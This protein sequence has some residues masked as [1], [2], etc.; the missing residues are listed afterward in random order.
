MFDGY[1]WNVTSTSSIFPLLSNIKMSM[2]FISLLNFLVQKTHDYW[3]VIFIMDVVNFKR[4]NNEIVCQ[5]FGL[6]V[7]SI[8][9]HFSVVKFGHIITECVCGET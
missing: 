7:N 2:V 4:F 1:S 3:S 8:D 9:Q 6:N 5:Y